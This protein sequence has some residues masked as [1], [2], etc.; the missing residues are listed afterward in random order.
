MKIG[1]REFIFGTQT[2]LMGILNITPDSF[3]DGGCFFS[4]EKALLQAEKMILEGADILDI[5]GESTRPGHQVISIEEEI[6]RVVPVISAIKKVF[7]EIPVSID[8]YKAPVA[9]AAVLAG[10]DLLNDVWGFRADEDMAKLAAEYELP[11][12]LMHNRKNLPYQNFLADFLEDLKQSLAIA[13]KY[14]VKQEK[15]IL[16]PGI[17]FAKTYEE[18]RM[19]MNHLE[20]IKE[21]FPTYPLL[22]AT[23]RKSMIGKALGDVPTQDRLFGTVATTVLGITKGCDM[24]RVHDVKENKEAILMTDAIVRM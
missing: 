9:R 10:A 18:N 19:I 5:G 17:G 12:C 15:I 4:V 11:C 22:L 3:S 23:S 21:T 7:P 24:V 1:K 16:D 6:A 20:C 2:Y 13:E 14:G 8:T